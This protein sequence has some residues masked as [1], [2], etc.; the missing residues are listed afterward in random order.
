MNILNTISSL[1]VNSGG[2]SFSVNLTVSALND[3]GVKTNILTFEAVEADTLICDA[4][5]IHTIAQG[6]ESRFG[7]STAYRNY[8]NNSEYDLY[9]IQG[10]WQY[11]A[12]ITAKLARRKLKPYIITPRG[13][14]YPQ[15]LQSSAFIKRLS[16]GL[17]QMNDLQKAACIHA[18]CIEEMNQLRRLGIKSPI[19][20]IAN[21]IRFDKTVA[22]RAP[23]NK[24]RIGFLGRLHERKNV[25]RLI[26]AWANLTDITKECELVIIGA[27]DD[28]YL[29]FLR[30]EAKRLNLDNVA[31]TGFLSGREKEDALSSISFLAVPSDFENFGNIVTE[32]LVRGVPVIASKGTPWEEL[33]THRCGW[34]V[35]NDVD[36]IANTIREALSLSETERTTMGERGKKLIAENYTVD[37]VADKMKMLYNWIINGGTKPDFVNL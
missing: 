3:L 28:S 21:P 12:Y 31:F 19:A 11:H 14:L 33:N 25:E 34:W 9:H 18:T 13:M 37:I 16:L 36:T 22:D 24:M 1:G 35:D 8:I 15:A 5:Y 32:A 30:K 4:K 6:N 26:Y 23:L 27:G 2:P 10:A 20:V 17:F 7:Y 29:E